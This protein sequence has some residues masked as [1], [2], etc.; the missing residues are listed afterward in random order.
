MKIGLCSRTDRPAAI[1]AAATAARRL[2]GEGHEVAEV[3]LGATSLASDLAG[4]AVVCVFGGDGTVLRAARQIAPLGVPLLGVNL[5]R[6]GFLTGTSVAELDGTMAEVLAG[7]FECED[8]TVLEA[9]VTRGGSVFRRV[10]ALNDVVV[11]RG[12]QV[13]AIHVDVHIGG[14]PFTVYW[15]DGI[16]VATATGSTAYAMSVGGP[17]MLPDAQALLIVPIAPHLSFG[18]AVVL[19]PGERVALEVLDEPARI[20]VDGQEEHDLRGGD[21]IDV[22]RSALP[23]R[24]V[25]TP[26]MRPFLQLLRQ[27]ILKEG[28]VTQ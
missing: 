17:L 21:R 24:F 13:R 8:R 12:A 22:R 19:P 27:K 14:E 4:A 2:R 25:R 9:T 5:G 6:L 23:A 3:S 26:T 7:R 20:S 16:I 15:A 18:N 10:T 11:A 28:G 1:D